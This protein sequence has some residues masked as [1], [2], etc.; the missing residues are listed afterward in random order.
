MKTWMKNRKILGQSLLLLLAFVIAGSVLITIANYIPINAEIR[1]ASLAQLGGE[2]EFPAVPSMEGG[3][4]DFHSTDP[5]TL[6]LA[7][8]ALMVKMALYEGED[9]GLRQA[10]RCYSTQYEAEYSR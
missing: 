2:G 6:E 10:F 4:G 3:Y 7:T 8:D 1:E 5:T 9:A